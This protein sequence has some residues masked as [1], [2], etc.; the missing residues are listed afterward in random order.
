MRR[1]V[2]IVVWQ[3]KAYIPVS[4]QLELGGWL[5]QDPVY[6]TDLNMESMRSAI[7]NV[8]QAQDS[9]LSSAVDEERKKKKD[10]ILRATKA[11]SWYEL[12]KTGASYSID[13]LEDMIRVDMTYPGAKHKFQFDPDKTQEFS[14]NTKLTNI[15]AVILEDI[16][17][18]PVSQGHARS[19]SL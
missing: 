11:K 10:P 8:L 3:G 13:W 16:K 2:S 4:T 17:S 18:R 15:L 7:E 5:D 1:N 14:T 6:K 19:V 9:D 12:A